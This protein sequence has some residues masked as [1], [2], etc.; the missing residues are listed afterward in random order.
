MGRTAKIIFQAGCQLVSRAAYGGDKL[1]KRVWQEILA[2]DYVAQKFV[3]PGER[4][5]SKDDTGQV[6]KFNMR[7]YT[8]EDSNMSITAKL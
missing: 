6:M 2:K 1:T 8:Y 3:T 4:K 5:V 7:A